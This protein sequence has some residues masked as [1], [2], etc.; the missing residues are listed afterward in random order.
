[1]NTFE[2][3]V[4]R[5][6][7]THWPVVVER[8]A[9]G[10]FLPVRREGILHL[11]LVELTSQST[12][13]DYGTV[14]GKALFGDEQLRVAFDQALNKRDNPLH[15]LLFVEDAEL[16]TL[17]WERLCAPLDGTFTGRWDFLGL[18]QRVPFSLYLPSVTDQRF[19]PIGRRDLR[20]LILVASPD[21]PKNG[22]RL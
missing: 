22:F 9:S 3:T 21:D 4:Q 17:R 8:S 10:A 12:P 18:N 14:L 6:L 20:A 5:K 19:P 15:V 2:I 13:R 1:M 11:D 7:D 16:R